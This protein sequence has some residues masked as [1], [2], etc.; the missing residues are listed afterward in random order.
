M[1]QKFSTS[2]T[3]RI[4]TEHNLYYY[5]CQI[6]IFI[7]FWQDQK[8]FNTLKNALFGYCVQKLQGLKSLICRQ[9]KINSYISCSIGVHPY[10]QYAPVVKKF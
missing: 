3:D 4:S 5:N 9:P 6:D 1:A 8:A 7:N 2:K 10:N